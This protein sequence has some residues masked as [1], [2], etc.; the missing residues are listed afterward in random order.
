[1]I[2]NA[3]YF[4]FDVLCVLMWHWK[5]LV[6]PPGKAYVDVKVLQLGEKEISY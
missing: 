6:C 4:L 3:A 2:K 5:L 1:M